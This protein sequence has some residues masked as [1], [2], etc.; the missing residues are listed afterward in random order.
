MRGR[1]RRSNCERL[2]WNAAVAAGVSG[3]APD[4]P[5]AATSR[6]API[7]AN[8]GFDIFSITASG[9]GLTQLTDDP[10]AD[11][12]ASWAGGSVAEAACEW[13]RANADI[14]GWRRRSVGYR[15]GQ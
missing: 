5:T 4:A 1:G 14:C 11:F 15:A 3:D 10:A 6:S 13:P 12:H 8:G 7:G 2:A 9:G